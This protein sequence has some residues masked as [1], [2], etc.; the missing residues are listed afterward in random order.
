MSERVIQQAD[1]KTIENNL[2]AIHKDLQSI[3][4]GVGTVNSNVQVV[5]DEVGALAKE[6]HE[7]VD[8]QQR[9]N[10]LVQAET[11]LVKIRQEIEKKYGHYDIV[12]RT[13]TGILQAD[14]LG[15][16]KKETISNATEE[17]MI[18]TPNYWL[19]PCL[20]AL[21]AWINDQ[22]ELAETALREGIKRSDEK[23]SLFFALICRR[24]DRKAACLK[25]TQR[26]LANQD[27]ENLDHK[28]VIILDA[29]ASGLLGADSE[30]VISRQ[31]T[32]WLEH[33]AD[34]PGFV[35][36][37]TTQW[38]E[39]INLKRK[40]IDTASYVYLKKYSRTWPVLEDILEGANLHAE[41]LSYFTNIFAQEASTATL[42]EQLDDI[43]TSL[44]TDFDEEELELR[45]QEKFEQFVVDFGGDE[46]R[47]R[48]N[49]A[50]EK[51]AFETHKDFTQLLTDAAMKPE[52]AHASVSTQK[53]AIALSKDWVTNA[54]NDITAQNRMKIPNEIEINVDLLNAKTTDGQNEDAL[55]QQYSGLIEAEKQKALAQCVLSG[56]DKFCLYGGGGIAC[57]GLGMLVTGSLFMGLIAAIAGAGM[58]INHFS[59]KKK[60][61]VNRQNIEKKF[62]ERLKSGLEI[63]R[64]TL[65]EVVDFRA[66][67]AAKDGESQKVV[68]FLDQISPDQYVRK[69]ADSNRRIKV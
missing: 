62:A 30:G 59:K 10:R 67:F 25:W 6:F 49:M 48:Q 15:I 14:D 52:S 55:L 7:F 66:E 53:F 50:I 18:S 41:I 23:T 20:V 24:A 42:K 60:I 65:A 13:T 44:V 34:K 46:K 56:F 3:D 63:I 12:R 22:P 64:A 45:K 1:L 26:Y 38:S 39:A 16:V 54:Y 69:L 19:A 37:Q 28:A 27:E 4:T 32:E 57:L 11:R 5:Y 58:V 35:E 68:D 51:S 9:E 29:Y 40:P 21:A 43:L 17:L 8:M 2:G 33:L 61:E 47:A 36:Q 31:M